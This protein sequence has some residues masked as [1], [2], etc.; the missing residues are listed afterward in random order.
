M[1]QQTA[2][3]PI[4]IPAY[5]PG[6]ALLEITTA[7]IERSEQ[8][9]II[10]N[11]GSGP[12][13]AA[14]F[15]NAARSD[16]VHV[17]H[18]AVNLGKGAALKTGMNYALVQFPDCRGVVTADAD[19]QHRPEDI[20]RISDRLQK[21]DNALIMGVRAFT[22]HVPVRSRL[23]NDITRVLVRLILGQSLADTQTGLRGVPAKLIRHL[24]QVP[25]TGYEFEL[26][27]LMA[28]KHQDI[29]LVQEP[30]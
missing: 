23:G 1:M 26:D 22:G 10:V 28:S 24:L 15:Q 4:V 21:V 14:L 18:H 19:G 29:R 7:L 9:I 25:S 6:A 11:D 16:R 5:Q 3:A 8:P 17:L 27:M 30:I 13:F 2:I 12:E 20:L